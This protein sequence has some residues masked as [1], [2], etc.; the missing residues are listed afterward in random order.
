MARMAGRVSSTPGGPQLTMG[1]S[2][3]WQPARGSLAE[4]HRV[5]MGLAWR[6]AL[7]PHQLPL[8]STWQ[9][10]EG[11]GVGFGLSM[12]GSPVAPSLGSPSTY[13]TSSCL[14]SVRYTS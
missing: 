4:G 10:G 6:T 11:H 13:L 3:V 5:G 7:L 9:S 1:L 8:G 14:C 2:S 12:V